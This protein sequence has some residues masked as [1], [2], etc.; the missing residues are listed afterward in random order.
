MADKK[1]HIIITGEAGEGRNFFVHKNTIRNSVIAC[2]LITALLCFGTIKG[3]YLRQQNIQ[4]Q[5][6]TIQLT[7]SKNELARIVRKKDD[8]ICSYQQQLAS[9]KQSQEEL[10]EGSISK[11]DE[12]ARVIEDVIDQLGVKVK[13][14]EDPEHSGGLYIAMDEEYSDKLINDTDR[15]L[16]ALM[17]MPLGVPIHTS[18]S[19]RFGKRTDPLNKKTAFHSGSV[20][21]YV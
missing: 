11:L 4:L 3:I 1:L 19:S 7:E 18:I 5:A 15:Y 13:I 12:R 20:R 9:L 10:L 6:K 14:E 17:K 16:T 2:I 8:R 21:V